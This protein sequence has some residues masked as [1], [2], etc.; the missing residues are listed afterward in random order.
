MQLMMYMNND[1]IES[2]TLDLGSLSRPGYLGQ[3]KRI[4]KQRHATLIAE[5][6]T[7]PEFLVI[8]PSPV[9][10]H[11]STNCIACSQPLSRAS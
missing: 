2:V 3:F 9:Y 8:D 1:L 4:L 7:D 10:A 11:I 5:K 6:G